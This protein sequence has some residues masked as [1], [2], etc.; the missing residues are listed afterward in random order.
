MTIAPERPGAD[1]VLRFCQEHQIQTAV[2]HSAAT[3]KRSRKCGPMV[4]GDLPHIQ[5][6]EGISPQG[7]WN[8]RSS[9]VF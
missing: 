1:A 3:L 6:N 8:C 5:R 7:T 4:L 9:F 2:G